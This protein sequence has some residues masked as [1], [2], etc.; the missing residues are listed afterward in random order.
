M[1]HHYDSYTHVVDVDSRKLYRMLQE[2]KYCHYRLKHNANDKLYSDQL[3]D[4]INKLELKIKYLQDVL[5]RSI[6]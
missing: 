1:T 3:T 6:Y 5:D 2:L 4:Y